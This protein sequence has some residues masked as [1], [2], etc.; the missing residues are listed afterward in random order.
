[1]CFVCSMLYP[2]AV[3]MLWLIYYVSTMPSPSRDY[4]VGVVW[5]SQ[6]F[7]TSCL[8]MA[9]VSHRCWCLADDTPE[10][11]DWYEPI[12]G[13]CQGYL[14]LPF[15]FVQGSCQFNRT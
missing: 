7:G 8:G 11:N 4:Y 1:M 3:Y 9:A 15:S 14:N 6:L 10:I 2:C 13:A 5:F 12:E